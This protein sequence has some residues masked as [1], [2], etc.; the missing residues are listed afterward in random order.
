MKGNNM[1]LNGRTA[2]VTG[3]GTG[4]GEA[5][6]RRLMAEGARVCAVGRT[7]KNLEKL[8]TSLP[9]GTA[10]SVV[11]DVANYDEVVEAVATAARCGDGVLDIVVNNAGTAP[12]GTVE[13]GDIDDWER[14]LAVNLTGP[15]LTIRAALPYLW[16]SPAP[17][18]VNISSVAGRRPFPGMAAYSASKAGLIMLTQQAAL[19]YGP[20]NIRFNAVCPGWVR[21]VM[22]VQDMQGV[23]KIHGGDTDSAFARVSEDTPLARVADPTEIAS[24]V[25]FLASADASF[26]T[27]QVA[28]VDGGSTLLDVSTRAFVD[29]VDLH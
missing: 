15:M 17:S 27:G 11:A 6:A 8:V 5:T 1:K 22:S 7:A 13:D 20:E 16:K 9:E 2:L 4:I 14:T 29:H 25:A 26:V 28:A 23:I 18:V 12:F 24:V 19:D 21:T 10:I 3:A